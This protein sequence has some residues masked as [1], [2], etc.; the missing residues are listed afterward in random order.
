[1]GLKRENTVTVL[2]GDLELAGVKSACS[3]FINDSG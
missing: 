3:D 2:V 1:M